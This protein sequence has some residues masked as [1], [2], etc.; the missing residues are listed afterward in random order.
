MTMAVVEHAAPEQLP[1]SPQSFS[2]GVSSLLGAALALFCIA[3]LLGGLPV[4]WDAWF[5]AI[6]QGRIADKVAAAVADGRV[7]AASAAAYAETISVLEPPVINEFLSGA[8]LLMVL[9]AAAVGIWYLLRN[10]ER[11]SSQPGLRTGVFMGGLAFYLVLG[12]MTKLG[13]AL[14]SGEESTGMLA[15]ITVVTGLL[16]AGVCWLFTRP[17]FG[18]WLIRV[19]EQGWFHAT[20]YKGN[21]GVRVRRGTI[22]ALLTVG[23]CGIITLLSHGSLGSR[24]LANNDW[25]WEFPFTTNEYG[26]LLYVP[27]LHKLHVTMPILL[28][29]AT[30]WFSWRVVNWPTFAD[31]LIATEAEMNKVSWTTRRRLVQDTIVVLV[32]VVLFTAFLFVVDI[33]WI[34]VLTHPWVQVLQVDIKEAFQKQQEK[35]QW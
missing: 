10:L 18:R 27:L 3:F 22:L 28:G 20:A 17:G 9:I 8:L 23:V 32:T 26:E 11:S 15:T 13:W 2:L 31:F 6:R 14:D 7:P 16:L 21:Q 35:T 4:M 1:R 34:K 25:L 29:A 24:R 33:I 5:E 12:L 19:E 30:V